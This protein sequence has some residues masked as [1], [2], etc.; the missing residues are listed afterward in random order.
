MKRRVRPWLWLALSLPCTGLLL[1]WG[2]FRLR[3]APSPQVSPVPAVQPAHVPERRSL[4]PQPPMA[5]PRPL[6]AKEPDLHQRWVELNNEATSELAAGELEAAVEKFER[7]LAAD[8]GSAVF[9]GNLA[10]ALVRLAKVEHDRGALDAAIAHLARAIELG[11]ARAD[12]VA[13]EDILA[14]WRRE[15][16][17]VRED[18]TEGS[19]RFELSFDKERK[20]LLHHSHEVLEQLE[21]SYEYLKGWFGTD[22][23]AGG[24]PLRVVLYDPEQF[25]RLTGLGD[26]AGGVFDGVLHISVRDLTSGEGWRAVLTHE[27]THAFVQAVA[28]SDVPGWLNEGLAQLM[29]KRA[30]L[31][32]SMA[33]RLRG[34]ELYPLERLV[35][36]LA[37]WDDPAA[38]ARAYAESLCFVDYLRAS[39]GD[40][41]LRRMLAGLARN[42]TP[43]AAFL[44]WSTVPLEVA[45]QDWKAAL[46][47]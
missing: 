35:G 12:H 20:D 32:A 37:G 40:E 9:A 11:S 47:R 21:E 24:P 42:Q 3:P 29:E 19:D 34:Q 14:R 38:I 8:P 17:L 6:E 27:L 39:F 16:E 18:W 2:F 25:D 7:C 31:V 28:G 36:S 5:S 26:W 33:A 15:L 43:A 44:E 41:A 13:L 22:P 10:E 4:L 45:F 46:E 1:T 30:G 23:M